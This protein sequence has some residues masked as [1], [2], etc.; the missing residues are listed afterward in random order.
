MAPCQP[1]PLG[2]C[3]D[4]ELWSSG[5][6]EWA[7]RLWHCSTSSTTLLTIM[8]RPSR[9]RI[10]REPSLMLSHAFWTSSTRPDRSNSRLC[11]SSTWGAE[12]ASSYA[13]QSRTDTPSWRPKSIAA[14]SSRWLLKS[15][16]VVASLS[17][18][19]CSFFFKVRA[20][21]NV[22]VI[23]VAN[24]VDLEPSGQRRVGLEEGQHL[25]NKFGC[26][27]LETSAA[28]RS[29]VDEVFHTLVR[30]IRKH[31][32]RP[33]RFPIRFPKNYIK[34]FFKEEGD[35]EPEI[36]RWKKIWYSISRRAHRRK[37]GKD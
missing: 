4:T 37:S 36:S 6:E 11:G 24:K 16:V 7:S 33:S 30:E 5:T 14:S 25:A 1:Q 34:L 26:P 15:L 13:T 2:G 3:D 29:H 21:E 23:L 10:S 22:P 28:H 20:Q 17:V 8:T 18:T 9:T 27:F 19:K 32:V 35:K 12:R 31:Q